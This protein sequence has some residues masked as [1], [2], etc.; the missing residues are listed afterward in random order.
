MIDPLFKKLNYKQNLPIY[1]L[2][3]PAQFLDYCLN[4]GI[5]LQT[6]VEHVQAIH[7]ALAFVDTQEA[8]TAAADCLIPLL[9]GDA[10]IWFCYPK[11]SSKKYSGTIN[12]DQGWEAVGKYGLEPV[13]QVAIDDDWSALRFRKVDHIKKLTRQFAVS[14]EAKERL[15]L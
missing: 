15:G 4:A 12:R 3:A 11:M 9:E 1:C 7:F 5:T 2:N 13:R 6:S 8:L 10:I 14:K